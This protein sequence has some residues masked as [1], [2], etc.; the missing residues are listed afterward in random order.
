MEDLVT[1]GNK[2]SISFSLDPLLIFKNL[3]SGSN[4][5]NLCFII[6]ESILI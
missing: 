5:K 2:F 1:I 4:C 6:L 3:D